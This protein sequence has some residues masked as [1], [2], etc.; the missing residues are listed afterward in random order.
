MALAS[1]EAAQPLLHTQAPDQTFYLLLGDGDNGASINNVQFNMSA[2]AAGPPLLDYQTDLSTQDF[3]QT[4]YTELGEQCDPSTDSCS[5]FHVL[6]TEVGDI[7]D[8]FLIN[9]LSSHVVAH[10]VHLHGL[11]Y[12]VLGTGAIP[13]SRP[14]HWVREQEEQGRI[15]RN[16]DH[17]PRYTAG[18][19]F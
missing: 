12:S 16:L 6:Q 9:P 14:L 10:P 19:L 3:C 18:R 11:H 13:D 5:C 4:P 7:V 1:L 2:L 17:P 8:L 15:P